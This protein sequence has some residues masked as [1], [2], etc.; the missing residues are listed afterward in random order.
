MQREEAVQLIITGLLAARACPRWEARE[1]AETLLD[2]YLRHSL[3]CI[4]G[5]DV[6]VEMVAEIVAEI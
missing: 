5:V 4:S 2:E 3:Y 1:Q 6:P